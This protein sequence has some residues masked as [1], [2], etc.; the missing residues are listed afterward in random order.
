MPAHCSELMEPVPESVS[1]STITSAEWRL[2]RFQPAASSARS[3]SSTAVSRIGSTEWMRNGSMIVFQ[4]SMTPAYGARPGAYQMSP[5]VKPSGKGSSGSTTHEEKPVIQAVPVSSGTTARYGPT[6]VSSIRRPVKVVPRM[7]S[8]TKGSSRPSRPR[9]GSAAILAQGPVPHGERSMAPV[10]V[11]GLS[12][13]SLP[14]DTVTT[15]RRLEVAAWGGPESWAM[16][17]PAE[18]GW[19]GG[20]AGRCA[21][22]AAL[23]ISLMRTMSRPL[24]GR[25]E[26][27]RER[28]HVA[29]GHR[30]DLALVASGTDAYQARWSLQRQLR[31]RLLHGQHAGLQEHRDRADRVRAGHARVLDLLHDHV[32]GVRLGVVG[33]QYQVHVGGRIA[34]RLVQHAQAQVV[35]IGGQPLHLVEHRL[36]G[37]VQDAAHDDPAGVAGRGGLPGL[38]HLG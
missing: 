31:Q 17:M 20:A 11:E 12:Q 36:A 19:S 27:G 32:A 7:P 21:L 9:A 13:S 15:L 2:K 18:P 14:V 8:W 22:A 4:R 30:A 3:R 38:D 29:E 34:A 25:V 6:V 33:G 37:H 1:R 5:T 28:G 23:I 16:G 35:L 24:A 26:V 10:Q